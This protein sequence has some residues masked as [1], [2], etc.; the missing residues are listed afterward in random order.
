MPITTERTAQEIVMATQDQ[1]D[2]YKNLIR[3][4]MSEREACSALMKKGMS[5]DA[6]VDLSYLV[7]NRKPAPKAGSSA[8]I[9]HDA[10]ADRH[11]SQE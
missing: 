7:A 1:I 4:G 6:A 5:F 10:A 9:R 8:A 2:E 11:R 3:G